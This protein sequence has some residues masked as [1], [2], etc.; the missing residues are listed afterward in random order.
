MNDFIFPINLNEIINHNTS[1]ELQPTFKIIRYIV[2]EKVNKNDLLSIGMN[3]LDD[4]H[5]IIKL[6]QNTDYSSTQLILELKKILLT[7][8]QR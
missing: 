5:K 3:N 1:I 7:T 8:K 6:F 4:I 2:K